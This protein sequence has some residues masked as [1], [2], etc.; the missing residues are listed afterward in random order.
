MLVLVRGLMERIQI[1]D[2]FVDAALETRG[3]NIMA[4]GKKGHGKVPT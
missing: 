1:G 3:N 2:S 4:T